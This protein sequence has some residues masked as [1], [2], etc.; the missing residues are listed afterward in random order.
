MTNVV[1][2]QRR[3]EPD[4]FPAYALR[5]DVEYDE[6]WC[7]FSAPGAR[8]ALLVEKGEGATPFYLALHDGEGGKALCLRIWDPIE[9][10]DMGDDALVNHCIMVG[11]ALV[12]AHD[13][14]GMRIPAG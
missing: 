5:S 8:L 14:L 12:H 7:V 6:L 9:A 3:I 11:R 4:R 10:H 2:F 1:E 13:V